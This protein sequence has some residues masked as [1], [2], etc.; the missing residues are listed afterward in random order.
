[1]IIERVAHLDRASASGAEGGGFESRLSHMKTLGYYNGEIA[2][3][4]KMR[5]PMNDRASYFGDGVYEAALAANGI[6]F[7][8]NEHI[9]RLFRS[10]SMLEIE[11][12]F[13]K[14]ELAKIL[15]S[16][17]KKVDGSMHFVY[18]QLS[19]GTADRTHAFP[20]NAKPNLWVTVKPWVM[21]DLG[22]K[23]KLITVEDTRFFHCNI[24]TLN[25]IPNIMASEKA[26]KAGAKE[27]VF[28]R[29]ENVT[30][31]SHSNVHI[32]NDGVLRTAPA[33]NL[34]LAGIT[35]AHVL[36]CCEKLGIKTIEKSFTVSD[37]MAA[38]EVIVSSTSSFCTAANFIDGIPVGGKDPALFK[39]IQDFLVNEFNQATA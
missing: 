3:I 35:R 17:V 27:A 34:I 20:E 29:G 8:L 2:E 13:S 32:L 15:S 23:S 26:K 28:H 24:K 6:I 37:M 36:G 38:D 22:Q 7:T 9:D 16:L 25:L 14:D 10:A 4:D 39:K 21:P 18:W 11:V 19:R 31:C 30:E 5:V 12:P 1:M 33:D